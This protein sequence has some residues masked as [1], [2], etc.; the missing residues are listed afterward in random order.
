MDVWAYIL[1]AG[2]TTLLLI[3]VWNR[4]VSLE[5]FQIS[6][7]V[8]LPWVQN[9]L[10]HVARADN[11]CGVLE[12]FADAEL[13]GAV[14]EIVEDTCETGLPHTV[15]LHQIRISKSTWT[16]LARRNSILRHE[17][18]HLLQRR[19]PDLWRNFYKREWMYTIHTT[20]P[21]E[22]AKEAAEGIRGNPDTWPERWACWKDRYWFVPLYSNMNGPHLPDAKVQI[23]DAKTSTWLQQAPYEWRTLF[24][25]E[26]GKCPHQSEHP[27]EISAEYATDMSSWNTPAAM[28]LRQFLEGVGRGYGP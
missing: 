4:N 25:S 10:D 26:Q 18:I 23:W 6:P 1:I 15:G 5:P 8:K 20:P 19:N 14:I 2:I 3:W 16:N 13:E 9:V 22:L 7:D 21:S 12:R 17:R 27:A 24:C 11:S 28:R